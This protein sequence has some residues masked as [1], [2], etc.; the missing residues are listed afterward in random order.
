MNL[1]TEF[2]RGKTSLT[3]VNDTSQTLRSLATGHSG[4]V[5][6]VSLR[7][8]ITVQ[9]LILEETHQ[10]PIKIQFPKHRHACNRSPRME[11]SLSLLLQSKKLTLSSKQKT[12]FSREKLNFSSPKVT[13]NRVLTGN[14]SPPVQPSR[15]QAASTEPE[16]TRPLQ[17]ARSIAH[18]L[19]GTLKKQKERRMRQQT[20]ESEKRASTKKKQAEL[21]ENNKRIRQSNLKFKQN[22]FSPRVA[23]GADERKI[24]RTDLDF[25][26]FARLRGKRREERNRA[27]SAGKSR[28]GLGRQLKLTNLRRPQKER[29]KAPAAQVPQR[30]RDGI[31]DYIRSKKRKENQEKTQKVLTSQ[32]DEFKRI[33][34]LKQLDEHHRVTA[35][36]KKQCKKAKPKPCRVEE[37]PST[38]PTSN[39]EFNR[40]LQTGNTL[41]DEFSLHSSIEILSE[42]DHVLGCL[43]KIQGLVRGFLLR[44]RLRRASYAEEDQEVQAITG[45]H[46]QEHTAGYFATEFSHALLESPHNSKVFDIDIL[47]LSD[48]ARA[49]TP[50]VTHEEFSS[51][52]PSPRRPDIHSPDLPQKCRFLS[53]LSHS[54]DSPVYTPEAT[55][56]REISPQSVNDIAES[57]LNALLIDYLIIPEQLQQDRESARTGVG[58]D[59]GAVIAYAQGLFEL[60]IKNQGSFSSKVTE[61]L[62]QSPTEVLMVI[63]ESEIGTFVLPQFTNRHPII[64]SSVHLQLTQQKLQLQEN[65]QVQEAELIHSQMIFDT[66]NEIHN[67]YK[68]YG[69]KGLPLPWS[70]K[71]RSVQKQPI[72]PQELVKNTLFEIK[73]SCALRMGVI[74]TG[75]MVIFNG[76]LDQELVDTLR[77][78]SMGKALAE[79][80]EAAEDKWVDYEFEEGQVKV[81]VSDMV[82]ERLVVEIIEIL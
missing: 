33:I 46:L 59:S 62:V 68:L 71:S 73:R 11:L 16:F 37:L 78:E 50:P 57:I 45:S 63:Q 18:L 34:F 24:L 75:E 77:E 26:E 40:I 27:H 44:R 9:P 5:K 13:S 19:T 30:V 82:L 8:E 61:P 20:E 60:S 39:H 47:D 7:S 52:L 29:M 70:N 23:W 66:I 2:L 74:P 55:T 69:A 31:Q 58:S 12:S 3:Q 49:Q 21:R 1:T 56:T 25:L 17:P 22:K 36:K 48:H 65:T 53:E 14:F 67:K 43:V 64:D 42:Q 51:P 41:E 72:S 81:D 54:F 6:G 10:F 4:T 38:V 32:A 15:K 28:I 80:L 76:T 79:D 35:K